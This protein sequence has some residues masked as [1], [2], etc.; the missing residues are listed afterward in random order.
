MRIVKVPSSHGSTGPRKGCEL[1]PQQLCTG[2]KCDE[3]PVPEDPKEA[4]TVITQRA[5]ELARDRPLFIGG[6]HS[7]THSIFSAFS[8][9]FDE[10]A[11]IVFDAHADIAPENGTIHEAMNRELVESGLIKGERLMIIGLRKAM[12]QEYSFIGM[13]GVNTISANDIRKDLRASMQSLG[14]FLGRNRD[15]YVSFDIDAFD[16]SIAPGTGTRE[17]EGMSEHEASQMLGAIIGCNCLRGFDLVEIN[18]NL[19]TSGKTL[20]LGSRII[21]KLF[22]EW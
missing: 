2:M 12:P 21:E 20:A 6:D 13:N 17:R 3:I 8:Q 9:E 22:A 15:I 14:T 18:P 16:P 7:I 10:P 1:A 19:D 4:D 11:M 5:L